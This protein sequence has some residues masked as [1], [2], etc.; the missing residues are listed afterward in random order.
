MRKVMVLLLKYEVIIFNILGRLY[1]ADFM[2]ENV[3]E[4]GRAYLLKCNIKPP[5]RDPSNIINHYHCYPIVCLS[6]V[7]VSY[8]KVS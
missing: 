2:N 8:H 1:W 7:S 4:S 3:Y 5:P 6:V